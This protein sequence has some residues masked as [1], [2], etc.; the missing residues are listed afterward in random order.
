MMCDESIVVQRDVAL[1]LFKDAALPILDVKTQDVRVVGTGRRALLTRTVWARFRHVFAGTERA[2]EVR[3]IWALEKAN[4]HW[5]VDKVFW[6][7]E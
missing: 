2:C 5:R 4:D 1:L 6:E 7:A 3:Q